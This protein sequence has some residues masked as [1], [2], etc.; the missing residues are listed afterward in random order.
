MPTT[1]PGPALAPSAVAPLDRAIDLATRATRAEPGRG[2]FYNT[3]GALLY[4]AERFPAARTT[5]L[6]AMRLSKDEDPENWLF[7]AMTCHQQGDQAEA[8]RWLDR[9]LQWCD[10][11]NKHRASADQP[12]R[13]LG[14][15]TEIGLLRREAEDLLNGA[16]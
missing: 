16:R 3:L 5:L 11:A 4:R 1:W 7:L 8:R 10:A 2:A 12:L 9:A 13:P 14:R 6:E 15:L